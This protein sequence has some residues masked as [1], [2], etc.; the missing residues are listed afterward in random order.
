M[1]TVSKV[2]L[3]A[4]VL[5][6]GGIVVGVH[7]QQRRLRERLREGVFRDFE[8]QNRKQEYIRLLEEQS[9]L[10]KQLE[11]ERSKIPLPRESQR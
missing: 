1:S 2:V 10:A 8:R 6:S 7:L 3:G 11:M 9:G 4:S 5:L